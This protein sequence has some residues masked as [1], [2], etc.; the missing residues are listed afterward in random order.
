VDKLWL[1]FLSFLYTPCYRDEY[2]FL[3]RIYRGYHLDF[4][5]VALSFRALLT[6]NRP[7]NNN[8]NSILLL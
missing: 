3:D 1:V 7:L 8:N 4:I 6:E 5:L 2:S